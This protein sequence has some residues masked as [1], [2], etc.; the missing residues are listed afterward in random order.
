MNRRSNEPIP[1]SR[2]CSV[3][4]DHI[5]HMV[6]SGKASKLDE[7]F[8]HTAKQVFPLMADIMSP[9]EM[10][11]FLKGERMIYKNK[12][13]PTMLQIMSMGGE[14]IADLKQ[15]LEEHKDDPSHNV[16]SCYFAQVK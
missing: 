16:H 10:P 12:F 13:E 2:I 5:P 6:V 9:D 8:V 7:K 15:R 14:Y 3:L 1:L 11:S 4:L